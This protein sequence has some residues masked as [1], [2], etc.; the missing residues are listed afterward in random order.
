MEK[1]FF[2]IPIYRCS[3]EKHA[4]EVD[5]LYERLS[6]SFD[7][8]CEILPDYD[9]S[10]LIKT[11][12]QRMYSPYEYNEV[13]GWIKLYILGAQIRGSYFFESD[14]KNHDSWKKRITKGIRRKRFIDFEKAF[15]L[16]IDK[17]QNSNTMFSTLIDKLE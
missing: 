8:Q 17:N 12:F 9:F 16:S 3:P 13:I 2:E 5:A 4:N 6:H 15:E 7:S 11:R 14:P 10:S 1:Y